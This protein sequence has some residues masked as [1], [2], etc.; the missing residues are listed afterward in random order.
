MLLVQPLA[1]RDPGRRLLAALGMRVSAHDVRVTQ[2]RG[3]VVKVVGR[4]LAKGEAG[5]R[6]RH[7]HA[8]DRSVPAT[9]TAEVEVT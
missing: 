4:H 8:A 3:H 5:R 9:G 6:G 7:G 1:P 2:Q